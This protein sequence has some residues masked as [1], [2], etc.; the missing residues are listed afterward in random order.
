MGERSTRSL[1]DLA[2]NLDAIERFQHVDL[3]VLITLDFAE[4]VPAP[5]TWNAATPVAFDEDRG[6]AIVRVQPDALAFL[7]DHEATL[8]LDTE[9]RRDVALIRAFVAAHG[10]HAI[11]ELATFCAVL[12]A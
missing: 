7:L 6:V 11:Y 8:T 9:Q 4:L 2:A 1:A 10:R 3:E 5:L 12:P